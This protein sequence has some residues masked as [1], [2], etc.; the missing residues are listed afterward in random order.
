VGKLTIEVDLERASDALIFVKAREYYSELFEIDSLCRQR[1]KHCD[2]DEEEE[3][4]LLQIRECC[5]VI[6]DTACV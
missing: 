1:L 3:R 5:S 4:F 2:V 6:D